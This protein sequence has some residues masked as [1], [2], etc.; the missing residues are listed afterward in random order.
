MFHMISSL[1]NHMI[2]SSPTV[3][4][5]LGIVGGLALSMTLN[6]TLTKVYTYMIHFFNVSKPIN[7]QLN[8]LTKTR[9][10]SKE[11]PNLPQPLQDSPND[12]KDLLLKSDNPPNPPQVLP[13]LEK[14]FKEALETCQTTLQSILLQ[15]N[16]QNKETIHSRLSEIF[17]EKVGSLQQILAKLTKKPLII[18]SFQTNP[19]ENFPKS[20]NLIENA[21]QYEIRI[22]KV[23]QASIVEDLKKEVKKIKEVGRLVILL[24]GVYNTA[25]FTSACLD[26][27]KFNKIHAEL[28]PNHSTI[29]AFT[30]GSSNSNSTAPKS[31]DLGNQNIPVHTIL[32]NDRDQKWQKL[33]TEPHLSS[34]IQIKAFN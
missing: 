31:I 16:E 5:G 12:G 27:E 11:D 7:N 4:F 25:R 18:L 21:A 26:K 3:T 28:S 9:E 1:Y 8:S 23:N 34:E 22:V 30:P 20:E 6:L 13:E 14:T 24:Y 19:L 10:N 32:L 2:K 15:L 29:L 17:N 33:R